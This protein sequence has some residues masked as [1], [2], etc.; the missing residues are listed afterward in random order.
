MS[1]R[2]FVAATAVAVLVAGCAT[3][4]KVDTVHPGDVVVKERLVVQVDA[5]WNKFERSAADST[6]TWT[7]DGFTVDALQFYV[8]VKDGE[9]IA[10]APAGRKN[11]EPLTFRASMQPGDVVALYE[12]LFTR[13]GSSF[14]LE[15]LEPADF[16]GTN[17]FRF[18]YLLVRKIDDVRLHGVAWGA[19]RNGE[20]FVINYWAPRLGF[21]P[22]YVSRVE[23]LAKSARVRS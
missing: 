10:P 17:G 1:L 4:E 14:A 5:P 7:V 19:V 3:L 18:E 8:G 13:D 21:Y 16:L 6:P 9:V 23:A 20:L 2:A 11:V 22:K 12:S 15:R